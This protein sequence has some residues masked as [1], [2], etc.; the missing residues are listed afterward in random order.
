M[1]GVFTCPE[2][3]ARFRPEALTPG[4][5]FRCARCST[6][7]EAPF[8]PRARPEP[9]P[10]PDL[11]PPKP[12]EVPSWAWAGLGLLAALVLVI[13]VGKWAGGLWQAH[14]DRG[15]AERLA[16]ARASLADDEGTPAEL[17]FDRCRDLDRRARSDPALEPIRDR[18]R[19]RLARAAGRFAADELA[20]GRRL[21]ADGRAGE[22]LLHCAEVVDRLDPLPDSIAARPVA[23]AR[24]LAATI[25]ARS[26]VV[27]PS[28]SCPNSYQ[29]EAPPYDTDLRP[30]LLDALRTRGFVVESASSPFR[31]LWAE[32]AP[33]RLEVE[34]TEA[35]A[36][37]YLQTSNR[38][39]RLDARLALRRGG[40]AVWQGQVGA[41]THVPL[42]NLGSFGSGRLEVNARRSAEAERALY[43]D[44]RSQVVNLAPGKLATAPGPSSGP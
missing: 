42:P 44:A 3:G 37:Y 29:P 22:A 39:F 26:G 35:H 41:R 11:P 10:L 31:D 6:L 9:P 13:G 33:Y 25:V 27:V 16:A 18:T 17:D 12:V 30:A 19:D 2:C 14:R 24:A 38:L 4:R 1:A 32:R 40:E 36:G 20:E 34:V 43:D 7:L 23:D 5:R 15:R 8:F 21:L 28:I